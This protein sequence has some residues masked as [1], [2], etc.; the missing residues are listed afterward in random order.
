MRGDTVAIGGYGVGQYGEHV[1]TEFARA[2]TR[3]KAWERFTRFADANRH[4]ADLVAYWSR[5]R[6]TF[7]RR[8]V[9]QHEPLNETQIAW[10]A[11]WRQART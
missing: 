6:V 9:H 4:H 8:P 5:E 10:L 2:A 11:A 7:Y 1:W 3:E